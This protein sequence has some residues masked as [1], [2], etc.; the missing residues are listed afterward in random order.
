M[1]FNILHQPDQAAAV[2]ASLSVSVFPEKEMA[3]TK[4]D[5]QN[6]E[7]IVK[8]RRRRRLIIQPKP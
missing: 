8:R 3:E 5:R 7:E 1:S 6:M 4:T 2:V